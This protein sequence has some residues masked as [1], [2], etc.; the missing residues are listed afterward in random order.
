MIDS[1]K[2]ETRSSRILWKILF[3]CVIISVLMFISGIIV[4]LISG[5]QQTLDDQSSLEQLSNAIVSLSPEGMI[6][7]GIFVIVSTPLIRLLTTT[8]LSYSNRDR[9]IMLFTIL[10]FVTILIT[11]VINIFRQ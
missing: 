4:I 7:I 3:A 10:S 1:E 8:I 11:F 9:L 2:C 6:G 5:T